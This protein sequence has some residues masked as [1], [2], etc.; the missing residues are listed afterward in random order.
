M[1]NPHVAVL[2]TGRPTRH[3]NPCCCVDLCPF[4]SD[5]HRLLTARRSLQIGRFPP[6]YNPPVARYIAAVAPA[7]NFTQPTRSN[8]HYT[9]TA[10]ATNHAN[11]AHG[12]MC[13]V[14]VFVL[15]G[16]RNGR[17]VLNR[18]RPPVLFTDPQWEIAISSNII[19][20]WITHDIRRTCNPL[21]RSVTVA[22][23][24]DGKAV[25]PL[26]PFVVPILILCTRHYPSMHCFHGEWMGRVSQNVSSRPRQFSPV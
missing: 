12:P 13:C 20:P 18:T 26:S 5:T 6:K 4:W 24:S 16:R 15:T 17:K 22:T 19:D 9:A 23:T 11:V 10:S 25:H 14:K 21:E 8:N 3:L 7:N 1:Q 2:P